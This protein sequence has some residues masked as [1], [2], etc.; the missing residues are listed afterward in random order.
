MKIRSLENI[1]Y[2]FIAHQLQ[3]NSRSAYVVAC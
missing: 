2:L 1:C 3:V